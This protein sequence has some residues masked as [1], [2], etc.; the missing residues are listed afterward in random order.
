MYEYEIPV[1]LFYYVRHKDSQ[2][3]QEHF[4]ARAQT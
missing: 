4:F 2:F 3:L 1:D